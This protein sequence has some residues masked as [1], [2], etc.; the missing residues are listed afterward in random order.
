[1]PNIA[2]LLKAEISRI[3]RK[4]IRAATVDLRKSSAQYRR[5]IARLKRES[6]SAQRVIALLEKQ[7]F[8]RGQAGLPEDKLENVRFSPKGLRSHR[9]KLGF[10]AAEY[11][12]LLGVTGQTVYNWERQAARP[13]KSQMAAVVALRALGKREAL[14]MLKQTKRVPKS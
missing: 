14:A 7:V 3:A 13:R 4:E 8:G 5:D 9:N 2:S 12:T 6:A 11:G 10:S 1:M